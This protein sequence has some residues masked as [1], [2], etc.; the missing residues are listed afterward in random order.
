MSKWN[1]ADAGTVMT[2]DP[3]QILFDGLVAERGGLEQL[4]SLHLELIS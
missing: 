3:F 1:G 2:P 4:S